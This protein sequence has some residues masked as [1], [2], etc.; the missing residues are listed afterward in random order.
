[1]DVQRKRTVSPCVGFSSASP[2]VCTPALRRRTFCDCYERARAACRNRIEGAAQVISRTAETRR[3]L[4]GHQAASPALVATSRNESASRGLTREAVLPRAADFAT[5]T[6][7]WNCSRIPHRWHHPLESRSKKVE[8][9]SSVVRP[10][11]GRQQSCPAIDGGEQSRWSIS[12]YS[13]SGSVCG[14]G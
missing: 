8:S 14:L 10:R 5:G 13:S 7:S 6:L 4:H 2:G 9:D 11:H 3:L 1:M 12:K